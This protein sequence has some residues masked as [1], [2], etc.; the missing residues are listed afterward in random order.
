MCLSL[1]LGKICT[2]AVG[3]VLTTDVTPLDLTCVLLLEDLDEL[4]VDL[5]ATSNLL[6]FT[7]KRPYFE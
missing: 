6:Y 7:I 3:D 1:L 2:S 4:S 5:N